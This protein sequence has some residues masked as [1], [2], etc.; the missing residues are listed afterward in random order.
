MISS[1]L[2]CLRVVKVHL[3]S[4]DVQRG[5]FVAGLKEEI[6]SDAEQILKLIDSG[7]GF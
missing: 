1:P 7:E 3:L 6:V 5:V 4:L 2:V